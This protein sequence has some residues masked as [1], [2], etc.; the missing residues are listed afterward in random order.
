M[1]NYLSVLS[2]VRECSEDVSLL[3]VSKTYPYDDI[4]DVYNDGCRIFGE[5]RI[6]E[7]EK[8][9]PLP[10]KRPDGMKV[11]LIGHLQTNK[12]KKAVL[13]CDMIESVDS[14]RLLEKIDS[15]AGKI[16]RIMP[17]LLELNSSGDQNKTGF[18]SEKSLSDAYIESKKLKNVRVIG[19][20]TIGP[21]G[22]DSAANIRAF[23]KTKALYDKLNE[24]TFSVLSMG[25]SNDYKDA[26]SSGSNQ[27]RI[28]SAIFGERN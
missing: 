18:E 28:G 23:M 6:Q 22:N 5:N 12:V 19:L 3:A 26:I 24:G 13:L 15:E 7:I 9:F 20:M 17:V 11:F 21:L 1:N 16:G 8:K 27:V 25:M 10:E 4:L 2:S 14:L